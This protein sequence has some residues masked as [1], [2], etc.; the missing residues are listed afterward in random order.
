MLKKSL[1]TIALM[2]VILPLAAQPQLNSKLYVSGSLGYADTGWNYVNYDSAGFAFSGMAGYRYNRQWSFEAGFTHLPEA[3]HKS[4]TINT[5]AVSTFARFRLPIDSN[6]LTFYTKL[7]FGYL[8]NSGDSTN[9]HLGLAMGYG[10]DYPVQSNLSV[11]GQYT[12]Y[13]GNYKSGGVPDTDYYSVGVVYRLPS[14]LIN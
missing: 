7:G 6:Q 12:H 10:V 3:N 5:N 11:Q 9:T 8:F 14:S 13:I 1:L 2:A 4:S